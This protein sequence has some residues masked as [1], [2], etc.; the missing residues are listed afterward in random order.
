[1][2]VLGFLAE[3]SNSLASS[4]SLVLLSLLLFSTETANSP[5]IDLDVTDV[6]ELL[7][8][9]D[10]DDVPEL[11]GCFARRELDEEVVEA[12]IFCVFLGL[13]EARGAFGFGHVGIL[14]I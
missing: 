10:E 7:L 2:T 11:F 14:E 8:P 6:D 1:V 5:G 4:S 3:G 9:D 13:G 12:R